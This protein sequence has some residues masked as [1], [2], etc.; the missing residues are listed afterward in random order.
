MTSD[1]I[2]RPIGFENLIKKAF[3]VLKEGDVLIHLGDICFGNGAKWHEEMIKPLPCK[4]ILIKGNHD[5]KSY[6]W[7]MEHGWDFVCENFVGKYFGKVVLF[8][9]EPQTWDGKFEINL[10]GHLH[11]CEHRKAAKLTFNKLISLENDG[12]RLQSLKKIISKL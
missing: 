7:Y 8:S 10:H 1:E 6:N 4:K 2:G 3:A 12:Y 5:N 9:H 11:N